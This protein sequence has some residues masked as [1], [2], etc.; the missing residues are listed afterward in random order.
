MQDAPEQCKYFSKDTLNTKFVNFDDN[1]F[2]EEK[3]WRSF[4]PKI[5][6]LQKTKSRYINFKTTPQNWLKPFRYRDF[7][8]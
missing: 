8:F 4:P 3:L 1:W 6:Q 5:D 7:V 2:Q